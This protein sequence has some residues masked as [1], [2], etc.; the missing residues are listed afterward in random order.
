PSGD[1]WLEYRLPGRDRELRAWAYTP[2]SADSS[3]QAD[4]PYVALA[5]RPELPRWAH[6]QKRAFVLAVDTSR[7]MYG[8]GYRRALQLA[9]HM[10]R[11]MDR[12]DRVTVLGCD[13][14][15]RKLPDGFVVPGEEAAEST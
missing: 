14:T 8:E 1:L 6:D 2:T 13:V 5:L 7:S 12:E 10:V 11:E 9:G 3:L 15:C 4:S